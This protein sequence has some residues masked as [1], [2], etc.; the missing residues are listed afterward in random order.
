MYASLRAPHATERPTYLSRA[1]ALRRRVAV[2]GPG[3]RRRSD[4]VPSAVEAEALAAVGIGDGA[5]RVD[6]RC[7]QPF[8]FRHDELLG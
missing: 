8:Q 6:R 3:H 5:P 2:K 4:I 1:G 7:A